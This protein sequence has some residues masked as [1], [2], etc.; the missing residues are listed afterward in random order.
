L[1]I[2]KMMNEKRFLKYHFPL[3]VNNTRLPAN[4]EFIQ[5]YTGI[6]LDEQ[7][8]S[9]RYIEPDK[10]HAKAYQVPAINLYPAFHKPISK[11]VLIADDDDQCSKND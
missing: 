2:V 4:F 10:I 7:G 3:L 9:K 6:S 1:Q 5:L 11:F 8:Q